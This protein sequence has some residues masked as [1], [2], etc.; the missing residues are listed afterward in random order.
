MSFEDSLLSG[1][2]QKPLS[3]QNA[4]HFGIRHVSD[5]LFHSFQR[6]VGSEE[7]FVEVDGVDA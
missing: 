2:C 6:V 1:T 3:I 7:G 5:H 4:E